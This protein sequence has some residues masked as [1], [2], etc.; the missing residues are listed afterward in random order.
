VETGG[1]S[2]G[3]Y[4]EI[5][6]GTTYASVTPI[7]EPTTALL[8]LTGLAALAVTSRRRNSRS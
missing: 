8:G 5:R 4:D 7:P 6:I 3:S 2:T 1:G